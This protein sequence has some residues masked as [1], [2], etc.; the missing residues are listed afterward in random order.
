ME[1]AREEQRECE[2]EGTKKSLQ[3]PLNTSKDPSVSESHL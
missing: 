1:W 3:F 2:Q